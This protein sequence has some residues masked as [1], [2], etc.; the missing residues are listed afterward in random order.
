MEY[1]FIA[2]VVLIAVFIL[3]MYVLRTKVFVHRYYI[4]YLAFISIFF[5]AANQYLT[6]RPIVLYGE[7]FTS[8]FRIGCVPIEDFIFNISLVT[9]P[10]S[11]W[12]YYKIRMAS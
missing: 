1:T 3:D 4:I 11:L 5:F 2:L 7:Q 8:G 9:L 10:L 12:E 6:C